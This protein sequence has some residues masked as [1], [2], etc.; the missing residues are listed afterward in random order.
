MNIKTRI[1]AFL[2]GL[3]WLTINSFLSGFPS[4]SLRNWGLRIFG[5][6]MTRNVRFYQGFHVRKPSG[7]TIKDGV[8]IGPKVLLDGR[9]G[10]EIGKSVVIAYEAIIWTLNHDY[11]D[12][13]FKG[14]GGKV[15][16]GDYAWICSRSIILP[17]VT[18][19]EGAVVASGAV[20]TK[21]VAPYTI[22]GGIPA[23]VIGNRD[24]KEYKYGYC[25][26]TVIEYL[27]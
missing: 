14:K 16:I 3:E 27:A 23:R 1:R 20:V 13:Y 18:I 19:G 2:S 21:D 17:G 9:C 10:L 4:I 8:S 12:I 11:N 22:V 5:V 15:T 26:T 7:I 6:K 25:R 24:E